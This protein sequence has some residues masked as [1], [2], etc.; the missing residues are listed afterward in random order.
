MTPPAHAPAPRRA[1]SLE[2]LRELRGRLTACEHEYAAAAEAGALL[3][4]ELPHARASVHAYDPGSGEARVLWSDPACTRNGAIGA[5]SRPVGDALGR[6]VRS[7]R[8]QRVR[9]AYVEPDFVRSL[10]GQTRSDL[11]VPLLWDATVTGAIGLEYPAGQQPTDRDEEIVELV[12]LHLRLRPRGEPAADAR[13]GATHAP[14][15]ECELLGAFARSL[16]QSTDVAACMTAAVDTACEALN[17]EGAVLLFRHPARQMLEVAATCGTAPAAGELVPL[18]GGIPGEVVRT[19]RSRA[20]LLTPDQRFSAADAELGLRDTLLAPLCSGGRTV[21]ALAVLNRRHGSAYSP[22]DVE[23]L[24]NLANVAGALE[25]MRQVAPLRQRLSDNSL[26]AEVGRAVTGTLGLAEVLALVVRAA[27]MLLSA[28]AVAV[29]LLAPGDSVL[30]LAAAGGSIRGCVGE[31]VPVH[32][33]LLGLAVRDGEVITSD[34]LKDD[35]RVAP[36]EPAL[37]PGVVVPL[38]SRATIHGAL[39]VAR[40]AGAPAISDEDVDALRKLVSYAAIAIDNAKLYRE[41]TELSRALRAQTAELERA[42]G[43]LRESQERLVVSEKM[44]ALGK[45]TAGIAHE[46]NSP[47]GGILNCLLLAN[48]YAT[49]YRDSVGDPEVGPDDHRAI[50]EDLINTLAMAETATRKVGQFVR[51]IK[52]QT[53]IGEE[54]ERH[55]F[56]PREEIEGICSLLQHELRNKHVSLRTE[57]EQGLELIGSPSKFALIVQN[58]VSNAMDAYEGGEGEVVLRARREPDAVILEVQDDGC[59]I[60][61]EIRSRIFDYLFT[62]KDVGQGTGLGLSMVHSIVTT[63]FRGRI[64]LQSEVGVGTTFLIHLPTG[65]TES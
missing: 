61:E 2:L 29:G 4:R 25:P 58:L 20:V 41:Q 63:H 39:L 3:A 54:E 31:T 9:D 59:G 19:T 38:E 53:R 11:V 22:D 7:G 17:T 28:R 10:P 6:A 5:R 49:E 21:G 50:A 42:Y 33:S 24:Q 27:E 16:A 43:E 13:A 55:P 37:G 48:N 64:E 44:A 35:D 52:G 15:R 60:P 57:L 36:N 18:D 12:A 62:T 34:S 23:L 14:A 40:A 65:T 51:T 32:G 26:I 45:L 8:P 56:D 46:I 47:L 1:S 30:S